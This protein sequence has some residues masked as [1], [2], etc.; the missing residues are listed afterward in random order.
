MS[1]DNEASK[2]NN[3]SAKFKPNE[4]FRVLLKLHI[5]TGKIGSLTIFSLEP[6]WLGILST[7]IQYQSIN[8]RRYF[9]DARGIAHDLFSSYQYNR[10]QYNKI[11][12]A[13]TTRILLGPTLVSFVC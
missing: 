9:F 6:Y 1:S 7:Q 3:D 13:V 8:I 4:S 5:L 11:A 12:N 10:Y 2:T